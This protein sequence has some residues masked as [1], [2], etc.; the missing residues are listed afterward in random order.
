MAAPQPNTRQ[1]RETVEF[2]PNVPVTLALAYSEPRK[3]SG[4]RGERFMYST[5]DNRALFCDPPVAA[6]IAQL[7]INVRESFTI[8]RHS[9]GKKGTP[10]TW[11]VERA[12]GEQPNGTLVIPK[13]KV[14]EGFIPMGLAV[15]WVNTK[16]SVEMLE[17]VFWF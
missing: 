16:S 1:Q 10:D 14:S 17:G 2:P 3:V 6:Q 11:T 4:Q 7:G 13:L 8:T 5:V 12:A 9:S 15:F